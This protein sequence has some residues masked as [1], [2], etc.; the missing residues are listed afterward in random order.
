MTLPRWYRLG[1]Q[2]ITVHLLAAL[3]S[4]TPGMRE[5]WINLYV[6]GV[7]D[8]RTSMQVVNAN[9]RLQQWY[10]SPEAIRE[11]A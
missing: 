2:D 11:A 3:S 7:Y 8:A 1:P 5:A 4:L 9:R 6:L 10:G